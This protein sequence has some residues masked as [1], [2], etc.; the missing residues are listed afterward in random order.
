MASVI[1][2]DSVELPPVRR[3]RPKSCPLSSS[4]SPS[5]PYTTDGTPARL[6]MLI[7]M[8]EVK[9]FLGAYSSR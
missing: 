7:S 2:P 5:R 9:R 4:A 8:N 1:P 6:R 3:S